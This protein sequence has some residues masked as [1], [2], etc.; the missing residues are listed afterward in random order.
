MKTIAQI[1]RYKGECRKWYWFDQYKEKKKQIEDMGMIVVDDYFEPVPANTYAW[2]DP[3][4]VISNE[5][6][7]N[8]KK[9][10][11]KFGCLTYVYDDERYC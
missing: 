4:I 9:C 3:G 11:S 7:E 2:N 5:E 10:I 8:I 1:K 6:F